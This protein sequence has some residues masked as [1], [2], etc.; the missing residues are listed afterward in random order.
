MITDFN[1]LM[2]KGHKLYKGVIK[3]NLSNKISFCLNESS[4]KIKNNNLIDSSSI[5]YKIKF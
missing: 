4:E 5:I 3:D 1:I 2:K